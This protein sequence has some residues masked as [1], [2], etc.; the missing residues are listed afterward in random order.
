MK[1]HYI[2]PPWNEY[3]SDSE[4]D[5]NN[6]RMVISHYIIYRVNQKLKVLFCTA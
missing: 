4:D 6:K 1:R 3:E 2:P 5:A